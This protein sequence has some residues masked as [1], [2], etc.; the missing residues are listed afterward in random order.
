MITFERVSKR[1]PDGSLAVEDFSLHVPS[2]H[3]VSLVGSSGS[4]KTTLLRMV[5][6]MTEPS[7]GRVLIAGSDV[8]SR[9][10]VQLRREIGYVLQSGGLLPHKTVADNIAVVPRLLGSP[11]NQARHRAAE[12][13]EHM[14][15]DPSLARRYPHQL[16]GGQQQRVGVA[17]AL[18][19][20]P[21]IVLMDEP[22]GA[23][24]PI[25]RRDLQDHLLRLHKDLQKTILLVTHDM[26]EAL[27]LSNTVVIL[28][29][30]GKVIQQGSP[31]EIL[32]QPRSDFVRRF[33]GTATGTTR[34]TVRTINGSRVAT[35]P[36]GI[37]VGVIAE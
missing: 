20:D 15:L 23:L 30:P 5:N 9:P 4:G 32:T 36:Q 13:M 8:L 11:R 27:R 3:I 6:R 14:G 21:A 29:K 34:L 26:D 17:R 25:V 1:Y 24:D 12:L 2:G 35:N 28:D 18:A 10:A 22:F 33:L 19:A 16:S 7:S 31:A 37:P